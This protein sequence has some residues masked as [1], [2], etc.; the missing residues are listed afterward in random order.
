MQI[1]LGSTVSTFTSLRQKQLGGSNSQEMFSNYQ[2]MTITV[3]Y[4]Q[5]T[6]INEY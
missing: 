5:R 3:S 1:T 2:L 6:H 4:T